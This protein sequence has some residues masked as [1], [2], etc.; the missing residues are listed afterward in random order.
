MKTYFDWDP[1]DGKAFCVMIY[2][3]NKFYGSAHCHKD[4]KD[5]M[6][7]ITG[8]TIA[9]A[10]AKIKVMQHI[11][12][13][14]IKPALTTLY[15]IISSFESNSR[16]DPECPEYKFIWRQINVNEE[17]LTKIRS[18]IADEKKFLKEYIDQKEKNYEK[19]RLVKNN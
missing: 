5:F 13:N 6:S 15:H 2:K 4:D 19:L 10:R 16:Y 11:K 8:C 1:I 7:E 3:G 12:N 14:E 17:E 18:S 9:E